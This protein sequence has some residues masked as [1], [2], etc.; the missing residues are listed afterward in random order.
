M[1]ANILGNSFQYDILSVVPY[2]MLLIGGGG[3]IIYMNERAERFYQPLHNQE[4][5]NHISSIVECV[6]LKKWEAKVKEA[7]QSSKTI[8]MNLS[9]FFDPLKTYKVSIT[10]YRIHNET[11]VG[12]MID[13]TPLKQSQIALE[14]S[15]HKYQSLLEYHPEYVFL[16]DLEGNIA[17]V[18]SEVERLLK[19]PEQSLIGKSFTDY[20][21]HRDVEMAYELFVETTK[22]CPQ[23]FQVRTHPDNGN[24]SY[25]NITTVPMYANGIIKGVY[26]IAHDITKKKEI[27]KELIATKNLLESFIE[28]TSDAIMLV[29]EYGCILCINQAFEN[30]YGW[31]KDKVIGND[32]FT[33]F[34]DYKDEVEMFVHGVRNGECFKNVETIR[35]RLDGTPLHV[36][37]TAGPIKNGEGSIYGI[38]SITRDITDQKNTEELLR[39]SEKLAIIGQ[40]AAGVAHEI[41]NPLTSLKGFLQLF[42]E[43]RMTNKDILQVMM[44]EINR[45]EMIT[46]E[47]LSLAKPHATKFEYHSINEIIQQVVK[48]GEIEGVLSNVQIGTAFDS[49]IP[50]IYGDMNKL[51]QVFLNV[52][53]NS[54]E[55]VDEKGIVNISTVLRG[56]SVSIFI[57]D[58]G[59]G[60]EASR[61]KH[62]GEPFYSTKE[63]GTGLGLMISRK[64]VEE[65]EGTLIITSEIGKGTTVEIQ[66]PACSAFQL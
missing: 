58:N 64:I 61:L 16:L 24:V 60:I 47:F 8:E 17:E 15:E 56:E 42:H 12:M 2:P 5:I 38:S 39:K 3:E 28:N 55:A 14:E 46:N 31:K 50:I 30:L 23:K 40:L 44:D 43:M 65:H 27:E 52:L 22:G 51:K 32:V 36:S 49:C 33:V 19:Q 18:N 45:I 35:H 48:L 4:R 53:K 20:I 29:D 10:P 7:I 66:L 25:L 13:T 37:I 62:M 6:F 21:D 26:G 11:I 9:F 57:T 54:I 63:K 59:T 34:H 41:R 1:L